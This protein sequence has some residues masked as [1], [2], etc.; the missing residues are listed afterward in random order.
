MF[1]RSFGL[2]GLRLLGV[3]I[4]NKNQDQNDIDHQPSI[5]KTNISNEANHQNINATA[6][7][8]CEK[9]IIASQL[10]V[11]AP[12]MTIC[13][14]K[15]GKIVW[16][17]AI[18]FCDVE[19]LVP[20]DQF[21]AMKIASISKSIFAASMVAP[22]LENGKLNLKSSIH[23][24][25]SEDE[26]PKPKFEGQQYELTID[27][28][29]SHTS[30][31]RHYKRKKEQ[32]IIM[33]IGSSGS[34][35]IYQLDEQYEREDFYTR[36]TFRDVMDALKLFKDDPLVKKPGEYNYTTYGF[37]LLSAVVQKAIQKEA[38]KQ[39]TQVEDLW[40]HELEKSWNMKDTYLDHD[41][42]LI[43]MRSRH[44]RRDGR[45]KELINAP[46][47]DTSSKWAGGGLVSNTTDLVNFA[48]KL[49]DLYKG[50]DSSVNVKRKTLELMWTNIND[51]N[52]GLGF[53]LSHNDKNELMVYHTGQ[54]VGSSSILIIKPESEIIVAILT[55]LEK[56]NLT[57]L[58]SFIAQEFR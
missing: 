51:N 47:I 1:K 40:I 16:R 39:N 56:V 36:T 34:K 58:G 38:G 53:Q 37:T 2:V 29:L 35:K 17:T 14:A 10:E 32:S 49:I 6:I 15:Q 26:F 48:M 42:V 31:L 43:P 54:S 57:S 33:P 11:G 25:L 21:S 50:R 12:G 13:V 27:Q 4:N 3:L 41:E 5:S 22:L 18:G 24:Y 8:R 28:L 9:R 20:C 44:Y 23:D 30:G 19:N 46:Y 55:N 7:R 45:N 52:Y